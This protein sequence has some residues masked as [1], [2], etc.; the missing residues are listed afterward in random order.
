M[1]QIK[2][3]EIFPG[4]DDELQRIYFY[5]SSDP[6]KYCY[7]ES[8]DNARGPWSPVRVW[9]RFSGQSTGSPQGGNLASIT[10]NGVGDYTIV[11]LLY[12]QIGA[13]A[14]NATHG[15]FSTSSAAVSDGYNIK[16]YIQSGPTDP[17]L[18]WGAMVTHS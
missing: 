1:S 13:F 3:S 10:D 8:S 14:M 4:T 2:I 16:T 6:S 9:F 18:V 12:P 17:L 7:F 5:N 15:S 11:P